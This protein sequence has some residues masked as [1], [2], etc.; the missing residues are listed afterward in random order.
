[1]VDSKTKTTVTRAKVAHKLA[2]YFRAT[3][4]HLTGVVGDANPSTSHL[5]NT[6]FI[7]NSEE[8]PREDS[9][10]NPTLGT[11]LTMKNLS[12]K[13]PAKDPDLLKVENLFNPET[14]SFF[15]PDPAEEE[16]LSL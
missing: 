1:M 13:E 6:L 15:F 14:S 2:K 3:P 12:S 11:P 8:P 10:T 9:E 7:Q 5:S 4:V 16:E